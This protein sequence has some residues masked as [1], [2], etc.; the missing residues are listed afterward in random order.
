M[1][2]GSGVGF[3]SLSDMLL[4]HYVRNDFLL[5]RRSGRVLE[6][7]DRFLAARGAASIHEKPF[8]RMLWVYGRNMP[9]ADLDG[10][11]QGILKRPAGADPGWIES[12]SAGD[13]AAKMAAYHAGPSVSALVA[14]PSGPKRLASCLDHLLSQEVDFDFEVCVWDPDENP[15]VR[16]LLSGSYPGVRVFGSAAEGATAGS[17]LKAV[18]TLRGAWTLL[19]SDRAQLPRE[20]STRLL[21]SAGETGDGSVIAPRNVYRRYFNAVWIGG[22]WTPG[23]LLA[24]RIPRPSRHVPKPAAAAWLYSECLF[25]ERSLIFSRRFPS[26]RLGRRDVFLWRASGRG[27]RP[28]YLS[29]VSVFIR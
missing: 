13:L 26:G 3:G 1:P 7:L 21:E 14:L 24:G 2:A 9:Q 25:F 18:T 28:E 16:R 17:F 15:D 23:R 22:R 19:V 27:V 20:V 8:A 11:L 6:A 12:L 10:L 5:R 4:F 29:R